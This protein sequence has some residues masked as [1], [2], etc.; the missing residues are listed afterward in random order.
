MDYIDGFVTPVQPG[1]MSMP[2]DV[3][4]IIYAGFET[5]LDT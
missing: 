4:R 1:A 2:F 3:K 5:L